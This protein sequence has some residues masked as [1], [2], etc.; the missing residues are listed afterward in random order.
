MKY[1]RFIDNRVIQACIRPQLP[2][3][4]GPTVISEIIQIMLKKTICPHE[5]AKLIGLELSDTGMGTTSVLKGLSVASKNAIK[6]KILNLTSRNK[7]MIWNFIKEIVRRQKDLLYLHEAGH[8]ILVCGFLEEPVITADNFKEGIS[9]ESSL[10][11]SC[12]CKKGLT[13]KSKLEDKK[14]KMKKVLVLA[15]H[16]IKDPDLIINSLFKERDFDSVFN[17]L[18]NNSD[19][20]HL[21]HL[22]SLF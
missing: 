1:N 7:E 18:L 8:H 10:P 17:E 15:E 2:K 14:V 13:T 20:L 22:S 11:Y 12:K 3:L 5:I 6:Y 21:V 19:R 9:C 4:C 16:N